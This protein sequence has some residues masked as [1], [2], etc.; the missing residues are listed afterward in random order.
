MSIKGNIKQL[1]S[2]IFNSD[3]RWLSLSRRGKYDS[4]SD[5]EYIRAKYKVIF[6]KYPNLD[7]PKTFNEKLQW[8]KLHNRKPI[9]TTM[10]DKYAVR[11]YIAEK[12]G[13][14]YLIP[15]IGVWDDPDEID[16]D[17]LPD[18]FVLKCNHNQGKGLC[19]C[20]DKSKLDIEKAKEELR[21]G[22][23]VNFYFKGR[24]W[25]YKDVKRKIICEQY[26][27]DDKTKELR[28]YKFYCFNGKMKLMLIVTDR[29]SGGY[30]DFFDRDFNHLPLTW[31]FSNAENTPEKPENFEK[32]I[33]L[34]ELLSADMPE[35]RVDFYEANGKI[36]FGELTLY[37]GSGSSR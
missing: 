5:E 37:D 20:R 34:A 30:G 22:L 16:F 24:E 36:Y 14:E 19:I 32:M 26:M 33:E 8:L 4:L 23:S 10:V 35:L 11:E 29:K 12:I 1:S 17:A 7:N 3:Y 18:K 25:P 21:E 31:G 6:G 27:E 9:Y 15:L 2:F 28:D 13:E